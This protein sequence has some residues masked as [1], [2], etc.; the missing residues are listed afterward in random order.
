MVMRRKREL[1]VSL[2]GCTLLAGLLT[3]ACT[4]VIYPVHTVEGTRSAAGWAGDVLGVRHIVGTSDAV[5]VQAVR[6]TANFHADPASRSGDLLL[7]AHRDRR[8]AGQ[9]NPILT[10]PIGWVV[11]VAFLTQGSDPHSLNLVPFDATRPGRGMPITYT[12]TGTS[13]QTQSF[14]F[15]ARTPGD[16]AVVCTKANHRDGVLAVLRVSDDV[17]SPSL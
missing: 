12:G 17:S 5:G 13:G 10:I 14:L 6:V 11:D 7:I 1:A 4:E 8:P 3:T 2:L 16:Y 9:L 15:N